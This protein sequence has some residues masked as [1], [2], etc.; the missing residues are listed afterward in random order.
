VA[1]V[2][3]VFTAVFALLQFL[4]QPIQ[5]ALSDRFGRRPII[6]A[7]NFGLGVDYILMAL[8]PSLSWLLL[9]RIIAGAAAGSLTAASA[10]VA[11][12]SPSDQRAGGFGRI[13][14][15]AS[16]GI[17]LGPLLGGVLSGIDLRAPFWAS[18]GLSLANAVYGLFVLPE[19]LKPENRAPIQ[20]GQLNPV[21]ALVHL[22][23]RYRGLFGMTLVTFLG[24]LTWQGVNPLFV[25]YTTFR[26]GWRPLDVSLLLAVLGG[27]NCVIQIWLIPVL[28]RWAGER[29]VTLVG[30]A[31]QIGALLLFGLAGSGGGFWLGVPLICIGNIAGPAWQA[32]LSNRVGPS[33]QGRLSGALNGMFAIAGVLSPI[34]FT[35]LFAVIAGARTPQ[36]WLGA[37]FFVAGATAA[38]S[39]ALAAW[40]TRRHGPAAR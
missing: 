23:R 21:G 20:L 38:L 1:Q 19:S 9:G 27:S 28:V 6:L 32:L 39:L 7:S 34:A 40:T 14:A 31:A 5:G 11:D 2:F 35:S 12:V 26:Y 8:A 36:G 15:A 10:Y 33:E 29:R 24:G 4:V 30:I 13:W 22:A 16:A 18:A 37:P 3:G 17:V 25:V